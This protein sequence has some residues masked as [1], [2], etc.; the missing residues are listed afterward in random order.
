ME[1]FGKFVKKQCL[2]SKYSADHNPFQHAIIA[3]IEQAPDKH[4]NESLTLLPGA[5]GGTLL[6]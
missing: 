4:K 2:S 5:R 1:R 6:A 3:C